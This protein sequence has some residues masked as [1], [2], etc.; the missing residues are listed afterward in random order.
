M[1]TG[2]MKIW[3]I[4]EEYISLLTDFT[5]LSESVIIDKR[6]ALLLKTAEIYDAQLQISDEAY[7]RA[8]KALKDDEEQFFTQIEL[9]KML[10]KHLRK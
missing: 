4:R 8:Q 2:L 1:L 6:D 10:P 3:K 9:N 5:S 7:N